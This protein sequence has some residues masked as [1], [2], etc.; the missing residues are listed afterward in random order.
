VVVGV[1]FVRQQ[2]TLSIT[3]KFG[4]LIA[5]IVTVLSQPIKITI[6]LIPSKKQSMLGIIES[7]NSGVDE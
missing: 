6:F 1:A 2:M 4:W 3:S 7:N 5:W